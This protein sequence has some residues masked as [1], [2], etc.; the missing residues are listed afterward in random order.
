MKHRV[1]SYRMTGATWSFQ[2]SESAL[3]TLLGHVQRLRSSKESVGQLFAKDL[4]RSP[5]VVEVATALRPTRAAWSRV[6]FNTDQAMAERIKLFGQGLHCVGL[7][8][9]HPEPLPTPST[10][11]QMLAREHALAARPQLAG[12]VFAIVGTA[13]LPAGVRVWVDD[14]TDLREAVVEEIEDMGLHDGRW[15]GRQPADR[16][17]VDRGD[18]TPALYGSGAE[19]ENPAGTTSPDG[20]SGRYPPDEARLAFVKGQ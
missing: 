11:D 19:D 16:A 12:I 10:D 4:T 18:A 8:H 2:F 15:T 14:G 17:C 6:T 9:T 20:K 7:W 3:D 5:I 13:S 1:F